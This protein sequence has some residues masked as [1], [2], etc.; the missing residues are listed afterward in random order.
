[1]QKPTFVFSMAHSVTIL[2][3]QYYFNLKS[4][5]QSLLSFSIFLDYLNEARA[6]ASIKNT[7]FVWRI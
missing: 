3:F 1:M 6:L 2:R 5:T 7:T 4:G